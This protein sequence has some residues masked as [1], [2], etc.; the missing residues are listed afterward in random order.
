MQLG[1]VCVTIYARW[2]GTGISSRFLRLRGVNV[3]KGEE[4]ERLI[5]TVG[6]SVCWIDQKTT[7]FDNLY[8]GKEMES[9]KS[10]PKGRE[11]VREK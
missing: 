2:E 8:R 10:H 9:R 11:I 4:M 3:G 1:Y 6:S 7:P 5:G